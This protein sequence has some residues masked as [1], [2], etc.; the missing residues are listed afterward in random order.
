MSD[1]PQYDYVV[2]GAGSAGCVLANR[3]SADAERRVLLLEAGPPDKN[4][5]IKIPAG[6]PKLFK[7]RVDWA[8]ETEPQPHAGGRKFYLPRGK[9]LGGSSSINAMLYVRGHRDDY[10]EWA[11]VS[12]DAWSYERVLPYFK[13]SEQQARLDDEYH[14]RDGPLTVS[15][16]RSP[17]DPSNR[18]LEAAAS[19]GYERTDDFNGARQEG[20]ALYQT[21]QRRG[22]RAS[23][24]T[25]FLAPARSRKNLDVVTDALVRRITF[26]GRRATGVECDVAGARRTF[27]VAREVILSA[28]AFG[29]PQI[30]ML[31]G[32]GEAARL[33]SLGIEVVHDVP[34]VGKNLQDHLYAL[35][36]FRCA[37]DV[38]LDTAEK[39][40][41][42]FGNLFN[43]V[44]RRRGPL[45]S[46]VAEAGG[47]I[48]TR[49]E[50]SAPDIQ[51][52]FAP[53]FF[54]HHGF[55]IP[56]GNGLSLG[57]TLLR[58]KSR[59]EVRL[60]SNDPS[61]APII[62]PHFLEHDD[63]VRTLAEGFR[64]GWRIMKAPA[65]AEYALQPFLP[66]QELGSDEALFE[67]IR[68]T[69][70]HI[71]HPVGTCRMGNDAASVVDPELRLRGIEN[72]RVADASVMPTITRGNPNA[73]TYM[74]AER[75]ADI[76]RGV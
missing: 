26:E 11:S 74:I 41:H 2:I 6:F 62:D 31:S 52:H 8:F 34:A 56:G 9:V 1:S 47:F 71:Y 10:D 42:I 30:L 44:F 36:A 18:F 21:T 46:T 37:K 4:L 66:E 15:D 55:T 28:G 61:A 50:L 45:T 63:D 58:P 19:L 54:L 73:P 70:Q 14:G 65:F 7:S 24:A 23:A 35:I 16:Q 40:Q 39:P 67:H 68:E 60:K 59:G 38:T 25:A 12:S 53:V 13:R 72:V 27:A 75:A 57:P 48:R 17:R 64:I 22:L 3:L 51:F 20:V 33:R 43:F 76:L 32:I 5:N 69:A 49:P 29:S